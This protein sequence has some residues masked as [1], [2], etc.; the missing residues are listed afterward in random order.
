MYYRLQNVGRYINIEINV[1]KWWITFLVIVQREM[2]ASFRTQSHT[3]FIQFLVLF[4]N[5]RRPFPISKSFI[6]QVVWFRGLLIKFMAWG[7]RKISLNWPFREIAYQRIQRKTTQD[8]LEQGPGRAHKV[9]LK[10]PSTHQ[11]PWGANP[12]GRRT[13]SRSS[14]PWLLLLR[15]GRTLGTCAR[16]GTTSERLEGGYERFLP[17]PPPESQPTET[18]GTLFIDESKR[19]LTGGAHVSLCPTTCPSVYLSVCVRSPLITVL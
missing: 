15:C 1:F 16:R 6:W 7:Y 12:R 5:D 19:L 3:R 9:T 13:S 2:L 4:L 14:S 18:R 8:P 17:P 11:D 10:N